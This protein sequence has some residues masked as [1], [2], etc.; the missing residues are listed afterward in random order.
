MSDLHALGG[1]SIKLLADCVQNT[2]VKRSRLS[3]IASK[4]EDAGFISVS[5][6][7]HSTEVTLR[8]KLYGE[9]ALELLDEVLKMPKK[10]PDITALQ[11][12]MLRTAVNIAKESRCRNVA[13]L[14]SRL[15]EIWPKKP[16]NI[17]KALQFWAD[18][19]G[20]KNVRYQ[21]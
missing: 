4:L 8:S 7:V 20:K 12:E 21:K 11:F 13:T 1:H 2:V 5:D 10:L 15:L 3:P 9:E 6:D 19:E 17:N 16:K 18:Y 14:R